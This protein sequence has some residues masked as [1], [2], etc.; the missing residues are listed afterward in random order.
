MKYFALA[1]IYLTLERFLTLKHCA[2]NNNLKKK[3][4]NWK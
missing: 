4:L 2:F 3:M 1:K